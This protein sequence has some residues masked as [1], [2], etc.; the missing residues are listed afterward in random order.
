MIS[1]KKDDKKRTPPK[2]K[3]KQPAK[4]QK[5]A[6]QPEP[7]RIALLIG[8]PRVGDGRG[9]ASVIE[10]MGID[11]DLAAMKEVLGDKEYGGFEIVR[12]LGPTLIKVRKEIARLASGLAAED[13]LL[14]YYSGTSFV[15]ADRQLYLPVKDSDIDYLTATCLDSEFV[16]SC[17]RDCGSRHQVM[18]IDGCHSGAFFV[19]NRGIPDGFCA[20]TACGP[21]ELTYCDA[22][23]GFFT[24]L[25]VD[26]LRGAKA[27]TTGDGIVTT[28]ELF[29]FV[30][31]RARALNPP[32]TP[33]MWTWNLPEPIPLVQVRQRVFL[34]Y[35]R[36]DAKAADAILEQLEAAGYGVW[37]DRSD[38]G[39]G[40]RW[41]EEIERALQTAD[42]MIFLLSK[43]AL[44]SDEVYRELARS[45]ELG[46][47]ILPIRL[48]QAPLHGW[49]KEHLGAIQHIDYDPRDASREWWKR[50]QDALRRA[51]LERR[52]ESAA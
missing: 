45:V 51:R 37:I 7:R 40:K 28:E 44:E 34:S 43:S 39:G 48:D 35:R 25:L 30:L 38:I 26:G 13:T 32:T 46:K 21:A 47:S 27:D 42:T 11:R 19:N 49:Y 16:L 6:G 3:K 29:R 23:G 24:R 52:Q 14:I 20:I 10:T 18:L 22:Q 8:N 31:P 1:K 33:Q 4:G 2:P 9:G 36:A 50:L 12:L 41:R 17:L 15:G 5:E